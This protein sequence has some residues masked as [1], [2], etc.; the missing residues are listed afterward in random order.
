MIKADHT[1]EKY[2]NLLLLI[3]SLTIY[4]VLWLCKFCPKTQDL[5]PVPTTVVYT[6]TSTVLCC[7]KKK[8]ENAATMK[9]QILVLHSLHS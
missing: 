7:T 6:K 3:F 1:K 4:F 5:L 9:T 2:A 8:K